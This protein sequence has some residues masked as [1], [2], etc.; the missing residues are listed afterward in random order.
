MS[1]EVGIE[2]LNLGSLV[3]CPTAKLPILVEHFKNASFG[4]VPP[5]SESITLGCKGLPRTITLA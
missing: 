1:A 4:Q 3:N 5:L 2:H